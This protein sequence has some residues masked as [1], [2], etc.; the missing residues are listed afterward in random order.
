MS[1][2]RSTGEKSCIFPVGSIYLSVNNMNPST[3]FGGTWVRTGKGKTLVGVDENDS[4]FNTVQKT[5][6][7][8]NLASH[9]HK[10]VQVN[11]SN[12][13][14]PVVG[15]YAPTGGSYISILG[16]NGATNYDNAEQYQLKTDSAGSGNSGNLQPYLT[17]YIWLR[18]S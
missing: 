5:G 14:Y 17:C 3:Y 6:G 2:V 7:S 12:V 11:S 1:L 13:E 16:A 8:K 10:I 9:R 18:T 15:S 4:D